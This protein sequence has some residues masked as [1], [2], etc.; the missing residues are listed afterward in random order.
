[1]LGSSVL[2]ALPAMALTQRLT[3][4]VANMEIDAALIQRFDGTLA[5]DDAT[6]ACAAFLARYRGATR[7][8]YAADLR[9]WLGWC[10]RHGLAP[11]AARRPHVELYL[12][13]M[14]EN[15][16]LAVATVVSRHSR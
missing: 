3:L 1:M 9:D 12:R 10:A 2:S 5:V 7:Q 4:E 8:S 14:E 16:G 11:L 15:R 6:M 13:D